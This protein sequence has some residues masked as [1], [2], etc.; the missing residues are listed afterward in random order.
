MST[1]PEEFPDEEQQIQLA[2][3]PS[4]G[5]VWDVLSGLFILGSLIVGLVFLIIFINPQSG[6]NP[7]P[8]TTLPPPIITST[9]SPTP[10]QV[11]P[12]TWTPG[13]SPTTAPPEQADAPAATPQATATAPAPTITRETTPVPTSGEAVQGTFILQEESPSYGENFVHQDAGCSWLGVA[14]QVFDEN[15]QPVE[16]ILVEAGGF[17]GDKEI[18]FLTLTGMADEYGEGGYE[19]KLN[20]QPVASEGSVWIQ[21]VNQTNQPFSDRIFFNT[22]DDCDRN[23]ITINFVQEIPQN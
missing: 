14:G 4:L 18:S 16:G 17:L 11:L 5:I 9:P 2:K 23:L 22:F 10:R 21:L 3:N 1:T 20:D 8:P 7:L 12:P 19:I 13:P 15:G 6:L